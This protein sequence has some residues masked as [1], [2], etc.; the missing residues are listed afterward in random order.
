VAC[1]ALLRG[2]GKPTVFLQRQKFTIFDRFFGALKHV[3]F[4]A[5]KAKLSHAQN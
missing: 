3:V 5:S 4:G 1:E 2:L